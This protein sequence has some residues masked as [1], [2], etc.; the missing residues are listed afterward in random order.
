[1]DGKP[2]RNVALDLSEDG[3][4]LFLRQGVSPDEVG[5]GDLHATTDVDTDR[6]WHD[7]AGHEQHASDRHAEA[8]MRVGHQRRVIDG[9]LKIAEVARLAHRL[10]L[11]V[12]RPGVDREP[13]PLDDLHPANCPSPDRRP[14]V[15]RRR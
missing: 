14:D 9:D 4:Q 10:G 3:T 2:G 11:D 1:M 8:R 6:V 5:P 13:G 7:R 15:G 12:R